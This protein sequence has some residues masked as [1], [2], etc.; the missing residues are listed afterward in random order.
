VTRRTL[1]IAGIFAGLVAL[2][3]VFVAAQEVG[4]V[5]NLPLPRFVSLKADEVN[6]R[7]GPGADFPVSWTYVRFGLPVEI[8]EEFENW[9]RVRDANGNEGWISSGLLS[10]DRWIIVLIASDGS[11]LTVFAEPEATSNAVAYLEPGVLARVERCNGGWCRLTH[12]LFSGWAR[13]NRLWG[14][15]PAENFD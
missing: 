3:P 2:A 11:N 6:V 13:Q 12:E 4:R 9:R 14:V 1:F 10:G 15:Y 8:I 7:V 5:T